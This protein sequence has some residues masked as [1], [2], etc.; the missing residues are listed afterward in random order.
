MVGLNL[1]GPFQPTWFYDKQGCRNEHLQHILYSM[2]VPL[3]THHSFR[4]VVID[5]V[6][7]GDFSS[8]HPEEEVIY[9]HCPEERTSH[10]IHPELPDIPWNVTLAKGE[11]KEDV[12]RVCNMVRT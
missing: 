7:P 6:F 3:T 4:K 9:N 2:W 12:V 8:R 1:K 10:Y 5:K 11:R